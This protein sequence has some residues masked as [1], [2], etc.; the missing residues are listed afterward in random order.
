MAS[1]EHLHRII[2]ELPDAQAAE[3]EVLLVALLRNSIGAAAP[4]EESLT[5]LDVGLY[6]ALAGIAA[7]EADVPEDVRR[8]WLE[9]LDHDAKPIVW[10]EAKGEFVEVGT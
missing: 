7:I 5:W 8:A 3:A 6:D 10:D 9:K 1:K 4:D 2:D